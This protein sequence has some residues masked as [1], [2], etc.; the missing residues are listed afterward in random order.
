MEVKCREEAAVTFDD[1]FSK[2]WDPRAPGGLGDAAVQVLVRP[3]GGV[4]LEGNYEAPVAQVFDGRS[5]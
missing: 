1:E 2:V 3:L 5:R 4:E